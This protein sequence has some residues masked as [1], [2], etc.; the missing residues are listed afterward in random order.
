M[1]TIFE[2]SVFNY[3]PGVIVNSSIDILVG[4]EV[5][6]DVLLNVGVTLLLST[7]FIYL[8]IKRFRKQDI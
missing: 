8:A 3:L 6:G 7:I 5:I 1:L 4:V 2:V